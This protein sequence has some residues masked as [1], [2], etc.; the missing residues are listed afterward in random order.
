M[1]FLKAAQPKGLCWSLR[2]GYLSQNEMGRFH[3]GLNIPARRA[4]GPQ[5]LR[6][7]RLR[8]PP[9]YRQ[10]RRIRVWLLTLPVPSVKGG[11]KEFFGTLFVA[12]CR[13]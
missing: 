9:D 10:S 7:A 8:A 13:S 4:N 3:F 1:P 11:F 12:P 6:L 2:G 5:G